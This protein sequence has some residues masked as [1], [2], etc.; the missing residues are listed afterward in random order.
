MTRWGA[1]PRKGLMFKSTRTSTRHAFTVHPH[2][3]PAAQPS[4]AQCCGHQLGGTCENTGNIDWEMFDVNSALEMFYVD[5]AHSSAK[6]HDVSSTDLNS[7]GHGAP[8]KIAF[9]SFFH[10]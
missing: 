10:G 2:V 8:D 3:N 6:H 7:S 4:S 1:G 5:S 9:F